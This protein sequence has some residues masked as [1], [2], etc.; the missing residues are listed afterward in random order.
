MS[1]YKMLGMEMSFQIVDERVREEF[2]L[3]DNINKKFIR[4]IEGVNNINDIKF[5][6]QELF[7]QRY[8]SLRKNT[9]Y[10]RDIVVYEGQ[11]PTQYLFGFKK[12]AND[13]LNKAIQ[14]NRNV[15]INPLD[16][17]YKLRKTGQGITTTYSILVLEKIG[18]PVNVQQSS[19]P[20]SDIQNPTPY[21]NV[22]QPQQSIQTPITPIKAPE[23]APIKATEVSPQGFEL[24]KPLPNVQNVIALTEK[25]QVVYGLA[26]DYAG[27]LSSDD[28][29]LGFKHTY[30]KMWNEDLQSQR[31]LDIYNELYRK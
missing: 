12:T 9:Q 28:F 17:I 15:G 27:T 22:P 5:M 4:Q 30:K 13:D 14:N 18:L 10:V 26:C 21:Q 16:L 19:V 11:Q 25:E 6:K 8:P 20:F 24:P 23:I 31:V 1:F 3:W 29:I 7:M 2:A